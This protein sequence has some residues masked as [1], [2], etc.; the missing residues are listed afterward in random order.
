MTADG[1]HPGAG[2][3]AGGSRAVDA[4]RADGRRWVLVLGRVVTVENTP[5]TPR[6][7]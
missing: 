5:T 4:R 2:A 7:D 1:C 3:R 6:S